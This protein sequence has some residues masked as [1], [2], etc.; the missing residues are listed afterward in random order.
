MLDF[1]RYYNTI[2]IAKTRLTFVVI[3]QKIEY[4]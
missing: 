3:N 4:C 1:F 2:L